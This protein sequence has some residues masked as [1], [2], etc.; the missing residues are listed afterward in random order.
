[1][2]VDGVFDFQHFTVFSRLRDFIRADVT[3]LLKLEM[4]NPGGS[5]KFK[6][7]IGLIKSL[8]ERGAL[9]CGSSVIDTSSGNMGVAL[10]MACCAR[11]YSFSCVTDEKITSHNRALI[12][13][14]RGDVVVMPN[15]NYKQRCDY[16][17]SRLGESPNLVW[18]RQFTD[19][20]NP[21]IHARTTAREILEQL[22]RVDYVFAG[23]GTGGTASG[24]ARAFAEQ[25]PSVKVVAVD[26]V[27]SAHFESPPS[28]TPRLLPGIG[29]TQRSPFLD[30]VNL[31]DA[32]L[33]PEDEAILACR[34]VVAASGW[35]I[36]ASSGSVLAAVRRCEAR[37]QPGDVVVAVVADSGER[38][39][40][41]V[42]DD[43]WVEAHFPALDLGR[44]TAVPADQRTELLADLG[45]APVP[46]G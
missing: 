30:M 28:A 18:T 7:A 35:L 6:P 15:S 17:R 10:A 31:H 22:G 27:G 44:P 29:A 4:F 21:E 42:Y 9:Q 3:L 45:L 8:E 2:I 25:R 33:V 11:G 36:G 16:I 40:S 19:H 20:M 37:F 38:Y 24:C 39:L 26:A 32:L 5:I 46:M 23:T 13:A 41:A 14:Y 43:N 34:A 1:M 12:E